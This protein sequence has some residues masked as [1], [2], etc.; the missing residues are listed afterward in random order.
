M[1]DYYYRIEF[2]HR[3][4]LHVHMLLYLKGA[5]V[6]DNTL[7]DLEA[8]SANIKGIEAFVEKIMSDRKETSDPEQKYPATLV[9]FFIRSYFLHCL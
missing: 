2:Q 3:G 1:G 4:S 8:K 9:P 7:E 6:L 5:P